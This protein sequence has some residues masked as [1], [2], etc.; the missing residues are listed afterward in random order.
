MAEPI[1][2]LYRNI[3]DAKMLTEAETIHA[4]FLDDLAD[5]SGF[6]SQLDA[7]FGT[8]LID[9]INTARAFETDETVQD[10]IAILTE[11]VEQT[12]KACR[13]HFQDAKYFIEKAH[14]DSPATLKKYGYDDYRD[15]SRDAD[16]VVPFMDLF[17]AAA[18][19]YSAE[20]LAAGYTAAKIAEI[21]AKASNF[22]KA[23]NEQNKAQKDRLEK[24]H[25]RIVLM[26]KVWVLLQQINKASKAI[27]RNSYEK[28]QQ[29]LLPAPATNEARQNLAVT[30]KVTNIANSTPVVDAEVKLTDLNVSTLTDQDGKYAFTANLPAGSTSVQVSATGFQTQTGSV[31]IPPEGEDA[32]EKNFEL[33]AN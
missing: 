19:Q 33:T 8:M 6:D 2:R 15:M 14:A 32:T 30:G 20:L 10:G 24:T 16:K 28:L 31:T 12:W 18:N 9:A 23:L 1:N 29:Y 26:N 13:D 5:F 21:D 22:R 3:S 11:K 4:L 27:Y 7:A 17:S 25:D